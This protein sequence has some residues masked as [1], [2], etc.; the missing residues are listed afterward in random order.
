MDRGT[1]LL[2]R[3]A[4]A[5]DRQLQD[6][7][8]RISPLAKRGLPHALREAATNALLKTGSLRRKDSNGVVRNDED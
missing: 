5:N 8:L 2:L 1:V 3:L 6:I 4:A 7:A